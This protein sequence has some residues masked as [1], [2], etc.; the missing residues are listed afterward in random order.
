MK[1]WRGSGLL[2][3]SIIH[4]TFA[5]IRWIFV[6]SF[7]FLHL[8]ANPLLVRNGTQIQ[9]ADPLENYY[10]CFMKMRTSDSSSPTPPPILPR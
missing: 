7:P 2:E 1:V 3:K 9:S 8:N 4:K 5:A 10:Y 6:V